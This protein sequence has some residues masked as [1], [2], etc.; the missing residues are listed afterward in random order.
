MMKKLTK[1]FWWIVSVAIFGGLLFFWFNENKL[2]EAS[3]SKTSESALI[4]EK[5]VPLSEWTTLKYEY[6]NVIISRTDKNFSFFGLP[7]FDYAEAIR[8]IEYSGYLKAGTDLSNVQVTHDEASNQVSVRIP[9]S[10]IL[11]N[12]VET[13]KTTVEDVK[14]TIFSDYPTQTILDE[15]N[16]HKKQLEEEKISQGFLEE[17]DAR[18]KS[19]LTSFLKSDGYDEIVIEFY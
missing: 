9:K 17:A 16:A 4:Q 13:E 12:V 14:G 1:I 8:L 2:F 6:S 15:I 19:L 11:D 18:A 5:L 7:D 3:T 10:Q